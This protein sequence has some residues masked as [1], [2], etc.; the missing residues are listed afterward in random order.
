MHINEIREIYTTVNSEYG[1]GYLA[2][3]IIGDLF[4]ALEYVDER[5]AQYGGVDFISRNTG[6]RYSVKDAMSWSTH[7]LSIGTVCLETKQVSRDNTHRAG[8]L[9]DENKNH[10][11]YMFLCVHNERIGVLVCDSNKLPDFVIAKIR[12]DIHVFQREKTNPATVKKNIDQ[13]RV[14]VEF[15]NLKVPIRDILNGVEGAKFIDTHESVIKWL[16]V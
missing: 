12:E 14:F 16:Q 8:W 6:K 15:H 10:T 1:E 2:E 11:H 4:S 9:Y 3:K 7:H 13:H 5:D